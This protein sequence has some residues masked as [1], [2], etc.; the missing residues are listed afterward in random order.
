M[1]TEFRKTFTFRDVI[2]KTGMLS[3]NHSNWNLG[4]YL[5]R[6]FEEKGIEPDR[7]LTKKTDPN[8][9]VDAPHCIC[10]YPMEYFDEVC[11]VI[12]VEIEYQKRQ[13]TFDF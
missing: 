13:L 9:R 11:D 2:R 6:Y 8:P 12:A 3:E 5:Q 10:H 7:K 4:R 1:E